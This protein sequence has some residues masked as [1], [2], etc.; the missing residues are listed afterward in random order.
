MPL[1]ALV[2]NGIVKAYPPL[3]DPDHSCYTAQYEHTIL[4][5]PTCK[6]VITRG[7]DF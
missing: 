7:E 2:D 3:T 1:K 6:E 4:L 5:R